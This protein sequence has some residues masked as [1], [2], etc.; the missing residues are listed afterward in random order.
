MSGRG[1]WSEVL[2]LL[3]P[4]AGSGRAGIHA[5]GLASA[6]ERRG[7]AFSVRETSG[8]G[9][10]AATAR[11]WAERSPDPAATPVVCA[12]GDGT[13]NEVAQGLA[14]TQVPLCILPAGTANMLAR[15]LCIPAGPEAAESAL[16]G[17]RKA[18]IDAG[19][20]GARLFLS[21]AGVGFDAEVAR[22]YALRRK[23]TGSYAAYAVPLARA[24]FGLPMPELEVGI[25]GLP[26]RGGCFW[27]MASNTANYGGIFRFAE[28]ADPS[29]GLLD[30][31]A[32][33]GGTAMEFVRG[34]VLALAGRFAEI[35]GRISAQGACM[36]VRPVSGSVPVHLDGDFAGCCSSDEPAEFVIRKACLNILL[37]LEGEAYA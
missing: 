26:P 7:T 36:S 25:G 12:G 1:K 21:V 22:R 33:R 27:A 37:P 14:G 6:L 8:A 24:L 35:P 28:A 15:E 11:E 17:G 3:N 5:A 2:I 31:A 16:F 29:D 13:L 32:L 10:A 4:C 30:F 18:V 20:W 23:S 9:E 34:V 19:S